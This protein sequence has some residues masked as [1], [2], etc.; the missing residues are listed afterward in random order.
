MYDE[1]IKNLRV[2]GDFVSLSGYQRDLMREAA[3]AIEA[4]D[5]AAEEWEMLAESWRKACKALESRIPRWI[6]VE[7]RLPKKSG[8][9]ITAFGDGTAMAV[10]EFMHPRDW[11]TEEGRKANPN[12]K[13]YWGGVTHW[14]P[15][16]KPPKEEEEA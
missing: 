4:R 13:W 1:L 7:E 16:P 5:K 9:Y 8:Y 10:N 2:A 12:G 11:L 3:D 15:R 6:P 14:M